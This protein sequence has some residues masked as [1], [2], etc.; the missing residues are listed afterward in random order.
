MIGN[1]FSS[2][3]RDGLRLQAIEEET[4]VRGAF[5]AHQ[6]GLITEI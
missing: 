4:A 1:N 2:N 3:L 6:P 5:F